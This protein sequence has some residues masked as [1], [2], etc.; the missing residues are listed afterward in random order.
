METLTVKVISPQ[1]V[2]YDGQALSI[3][4]KNVAGSF[5]V[6][7]KHSDF[8]TIVENQPIVVKTFNPPAGGDKLTFQFPLSVIYVHENKVT[9]YGKTEPPTL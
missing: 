7:P 5:D 3:S 2:L 9:I 4:S 1:D 6:L 8:I